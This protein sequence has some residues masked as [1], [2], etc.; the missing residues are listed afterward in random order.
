MQSKPELSLSKRGFTLIEIMVVVVILG[1]L[2]ALIVPSFLSR[3]DEAKITIVNSDLRAIS[4]ALD[5]YKLDNHV[6]PSTDQGLEAL[7]NKPTGFPEPKK[8][9]AE[10]YLKKLPKDPWG[11]PYQY[12]SPGTEKRAFDL[13]SLGSDGQEGGEGFAADIGNWDL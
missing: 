8:W 11:T 10:G 12:V 6:Y 7:V 1:I 4:S 3:P 13:Y 5:I 9:N 2:G